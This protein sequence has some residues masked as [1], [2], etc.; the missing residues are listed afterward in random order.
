MTS[1]PVIVPS[2]IGIVAAVLRVTATIVTIV[3]MVLFVAERRRN[4]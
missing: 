3:T 1:T 2:A 4:A